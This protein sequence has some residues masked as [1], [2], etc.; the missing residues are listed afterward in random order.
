MQSLHS[1]DN[2]VFST[3]PSTPAVQ[4]LAPSLRRRTSRPSNLRIQHA[5]PDFAPNIVL[6]QQLSPDLNRAS[7]RPHPLPPTNG[8]HP[9]EAVPSSSLGTGPGASLTHPPAAP[10][11]TPFLPSS[12]RPHHPHASSSAQH[13]QP[14][15]PSTATSPYF[16]HSQLQGASIQD[17]LHAKKCEAIHDVRMEH[18]HTHPS[19]DSDPYSARSSEFDDLS[20]GY[21][22]YDSG[23]LTRQLAETAVG[24]REMSKQLGESSLRVAA[25]SASVMRVHVALLSWRLQTWH[26]L[27]AVQSVIRYPCPA[28]ACVD[29]ARSSD[30]GSW[31]WVSTVST[32]SLSQSMLRIHTAPSAAGLLPCVAILNA[33]YMCIPRTTP[34]LAQPRI[35]IRSSY[36]LPYAHRACFLSHKV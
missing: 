2:D 7:P 30:R 22:D 1:P 12:G 29:P 9:P 3:P 20:D 27:S 25:R 31:L 8:T 13:Y 5:A 28:T 14:H 11:T 15:S 4:D 6:D 35:T 21:D 36:G 23:S 17:Y 34:C 32:L 33:M 18:T 19:A 24:V 10:T 26:L 16:V